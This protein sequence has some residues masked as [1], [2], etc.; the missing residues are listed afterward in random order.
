MWIASGCLGSLRE[1]NQ[2]QCDHKPQHLAA[3][4]HPGTP[5]PLS[6]R[7]LSPREVI[8]QG[9]GDQQE[10]GAIGQRDIRRAEDEQ[11]GDGDQRDAPLSAGCCR[12]A[13]SVIQMVKQPHFVS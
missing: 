8:Q 13:V 7:A 5:W 4:A 3:R 12:L 11:F 1:V 2:A 10:L 6:C 9:H